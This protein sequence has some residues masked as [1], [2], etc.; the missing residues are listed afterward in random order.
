[1]YK[2][3]VHKNGRAFDRI[4]VSGFPENHP[5]F[6]GD[7]Y[8]GPDEQEIEHTVYGPFQLSLIHI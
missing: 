8:W 1:M 6:T 3:Q 2:R 5:E 4:T 7:G